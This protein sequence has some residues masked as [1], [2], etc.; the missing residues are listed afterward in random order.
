MVAPFDIE[1]CRAQFPVLAADDGWA[2]LDNAGG[3]LAPRSTIEAVTSYM[4]NRHVQLGA[5]YQRSAEATAEVEAGRAAAAQLIGAAP[6]EVVLAASTTMNVY[7][8]AQALRATWSDG[9]AIVVT[10]LDHEANGG[11]WR[12]LAET[13][14]DVREWKMN[15]ETATLEADGLRPLLAD[16]AVK[17]VCFTHCA[18][19]VGAIH[20]VATLT[21]LCHDAG[22]QVCVDGVAYAPHRK[23]DV[24]ALGVDWYLVSLY[25]VYGPHVGLLYG[26]REALLAARS[27]NHFFYGEDQ[28]PQKLMPGN[29]SHELAA[30]LVGIGAYLDTVAPSMEAAF[31]RFTAHEAALVAPLLEFLSERRGV[32]LIGPA[33]AH[34]DRRVP[35]VAFAVEGVHSSTVPTALDAK[36]LAIRWGDFYAARAIDAWGLRERGGIVRVS[37]VHYNRAEE[38][39]RLVEALDEVLP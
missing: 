22:A 39:S 27:Q 17:L 10:D 29:V 13:G 6:D 31:E 8:L 3:S 9:D 14:L 26:R 28:I 2:Y 34:P 35:T 12:R 16:G 25:K 23:V 7:V 30:G 37:L 21:A 11:A 5:S 36:K 19:V 20:D 4:R 32:R 33:T 1:A 15:P 18:N 38:V 24:K